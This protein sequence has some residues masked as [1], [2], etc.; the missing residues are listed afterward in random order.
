MCLFVA[1][2]LDKEGMQGHPFPLSDLLQQASQESVELIIYE[3]GINPV[4]A[5]DT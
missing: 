4:P 1:Q 5:D 3:P 2:T